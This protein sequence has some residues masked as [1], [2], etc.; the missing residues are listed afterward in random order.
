MVTE[1]DKASYARGEVLAMD[2]ILGGGNLFRDGPD[3]KDEAYYNGFIDTLAAERLAR[4][5]GNFLT[6][7]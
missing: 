1:H 3:T 2:W 7:S 5:T 6:L 4:A